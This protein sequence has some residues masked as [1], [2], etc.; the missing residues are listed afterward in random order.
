ME[1]QPCARPASSEPAPRYSQD[2]RWRELGELLERARAGDR[3]ALDEIV[4]RMNALVWNVAR[5]QGLG[6]ESASDVVQATW[7]ALLEHMH[8]IRSPQALA[9]WLFT[10]AR[11]EAWRVREAERHVELVEPGAM[12]DL[13]PPLSGFEN[14]VVDRD[15]HRC[16]WKNLRKLRPLCQEL[17]RILAFTGHTNYQ[18]VVEVL[19]I[20]KGSIGPTRSRCMKR[21]RELLR[22]DPTWSSE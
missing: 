15:Q 12:T 1:S 2:V 3:G 9:A 14:D 11:R 10:V 16:L 19:D 4:D 5:A 6:A 20:P 21:L 8:T 13:P 17:L 7:V 22:D 18:A